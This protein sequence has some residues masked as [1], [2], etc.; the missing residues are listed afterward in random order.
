MSMRKGRKAQ[1]IVQPFTREALRP[2]TKVLPPPNNTPIAIVAMT[3]AQAANPDFPQYNWT[4]STQSYILSSFFW[5]Y[6]ISIFPAGLFARR[7]GAKTILLIAATGSSCAC[8]LIPL[9]AQIGDWKLFCALRMLQG[10]FQGCFNPCLHTLLSVWVPPSERSRL[11]GLVYAGGYLGNVVT[12]ATSGLIAVSSFG[13]PGIYYISGSM[14]LLWGIV[15][16]F[17]GSSSP[18]ENGYISSR[19]K[20][21][22]QTCLGQVTKTQVIK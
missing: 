19:E 8:L 14:G 3:D 4:P 1:R 18:E 15:Y 2:D 20:T 21:Y 11:G 13:W 7:F 17:T 12:T 22:I 6:L 16:F 10:L 5:G 9:G